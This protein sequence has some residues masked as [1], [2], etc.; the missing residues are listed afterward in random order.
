MRINY[1]IHED[2]DNKTF[3]RVK[4]RPTQTPSL[5]QVLWYKETISYQIIIESTEMKQILST[6]LANSKTFFLYISALQIITEH[7]DS[8]CDQSR[9]VH[10]SGGQHHCHGHRP[11]QQ[12]QLILLYCYM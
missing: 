7:D 1:S 6:F 5:Q 8:D 3:P 2:F 9:S 4:P 12:L 11:G 10:L